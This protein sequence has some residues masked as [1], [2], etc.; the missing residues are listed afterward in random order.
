MG[1]NAVLHTRVHAIKG[2]ARSD[3][4]LVCASLATPPTFPEVFYSRTLFHVFHPDGLT[5]GKS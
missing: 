1:M 4:F 3:P 5:E 2:H